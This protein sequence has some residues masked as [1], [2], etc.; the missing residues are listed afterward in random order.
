MAVAA[1]KTGKDLVIYTTYSRD[2]TLID[3]ARSYGAKVIPVY[4]TQRTARGTR[5]EFVPIG[6]V[7]KE[8]KAY[9]SRS[10]GIL[11][12]ISG[13]Y[14]RIRALMDF[15]RNALS[16]AANGIS[17]K[18]IWVAGRSGA[19]VSV[20]SSVFPKANLL[21]VKTM[22]D[23]IDLPRNARIAGISTGYVPTAAPYSTNPVDGRL[24]DYFVK[25]SMPGD[26]IWNSFSVDTLE[27][28]EI[29]QPRITPPEVALT[30]PIDDTQGESEFPSQ[31]RLAFM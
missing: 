19:A 27:V 9:H 14:D 13:S 6:E 22:T 7:A 31:P 24:W 26:Y 23:R 10:G 20:L 28:L 18:R 29:V 8:A 1:K 11:R 5:K 12:Y 3:K 15:Y 16:V 2:N 25:K 4:R 30:R 21:V 17:P